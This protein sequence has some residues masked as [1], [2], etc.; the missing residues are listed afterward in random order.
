MDQIYNHLAKNHFMSGG[1]FRHPVVLMTA[2]GG[3]YNDAAQHSQTLYSL[4]AHVPG[5][6]V[7]VPSNAY[8]AKGLMI[9]AIQ[10]DNPVMYFF[11]KGLLG[12]G[13]MPSDDWAEVHVPEESYAIPL[14][15]ARVV[16]Q[17]TDMSIITIGAMVPK[18]MKAREL[19]A[20]EGISA[21]VV[22]LRTLVPLDKETVL[23]TVKKTHRVLIVDED[24]R[25]FGMSGEIS[26]ILAEEALDYLEAPVRRLAVPDVPIPYSRVL[27]QAVIPSAEGIAQ[28]LR[29]VMK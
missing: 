17:G 20:G 26:A 10:D 16:G 18:A 5:L 22:D 29:A 4:F 19:V 6:K 1:S 12:L 7:V 15:Q 3:G 13:W 11:H 14:G 24:Y 8:D 27:E 28:A 25:S 21:E 23:D 2:I 9:S